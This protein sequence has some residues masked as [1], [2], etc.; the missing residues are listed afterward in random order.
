[1]TA[2]NPSESVGAPG[3]DDADLQPFLAAFAADRAAGRPRT[4][5]FYLG[6][7]PGRESD[8]AERFAMLLAVEDHGVEPPPAAIGPYRI[9]RELGRGAQGVV[10]LAIDPRLA[11]PV[12][13]KV[14]TGRGFPDAVARARFLREARVAGRLEHPN[15]CTVHDTGVH[16]G[17]P[18]LVLRY[19]DGEAL[20]RASAPM[21]TT[22]VGVDATLHLVE[23]LARAVHVAHEAG[24]VH[25][26]L[27]PGNVMLDRGGEPIVLDFGLAQDD[28]DDLL[29][30]AT[31]RIGTPAYMAPEQLEP[32]LGSVD[33]RADVWSLGIILWERLVGQRP[34]LAPTSTS[35]GHAVVHAPLPDPRRANRLLSRELAVVLATV[36]QRAPDHRYRTALDLAEDLRRVRLGLPILARPPGPVVRCV[37]WIGRNRLVSALGGGLLLSMAVGLT[38]SV[39]ANRELTTALGSAQWRADAHTLEVHTMNNRQVWRRDENDLWMIELT[40]RR[41]EELLARRDAHAGQFAAIAADDGLSRQRLEDLLVGLD[42]LRNDAFSPLAWLHH[43]ERLVREE[44]RVTVDDARSQWNHALAEIAATPGYEGLAA[45]PQLG[46]LPLGRDPASGLQEFALWRSGRTPVRDAG[47][48]LSLELDCAVVLVLVPRGTLPAAGERAAVVVAPFLVGKHEVTQAQ[49]IALTGPHGPPPPAEH[50]GQKLPF[51]DVQYENWYEQLHCN[52]LRLPDEVQWEYAARAGAT[53]RWPC[54]DDP[55]CVSRIASRGGASPV[56]A[57]GA[58]AFGLHDVIGNVAEFCQDADDDIAKAPGRPHVHR[59]GHHADAV[60]AADLVARGS[61]FGRTVSPLVGARVI[62]LWQ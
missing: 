22:R 35:L 45:R 15:L 23:K 57:F 61:L 8:V 43:K 44:R 37:R 30:L 24:V 52:G 62:R 33:R 49:W 4:L 19:V 56:G 3:A 31:D 48:R 20:S 18:Y 21:G 34:F 29:T 40:I 5:A 58:N 25:R 55:A 1:M 13:V 6:L 14:L 32:A 38:L 27:K 2:G 16:R 59:G 51:A 41:F 28:S 46:L 53:G 10:Y 39:R 9:E 11:R 50:L 17:D 7:C 54:G 60:D 12:A 26:D 42:R 47:G 36:L